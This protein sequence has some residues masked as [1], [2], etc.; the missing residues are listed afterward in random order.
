MRFARWD[1]SHESLKLPTRG[2]VYHMCYF[3]VDKVVQDLERIFAF[4]LA[5]LICTKQMYAIEV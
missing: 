4:V 3:E 1:G 5:S 2:T